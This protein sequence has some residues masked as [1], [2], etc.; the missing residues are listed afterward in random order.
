[1]GWLLPV[2]TPGGV[3]SGFDEA[4]SGS[5]IVRLGDRLLCLDF[6]HYR[7]WRAAAAAPQAEEL[8]TWGIAEGI[9]DAADRVRQLRDAGLLIEDG[10]ELQLLAGRLALRLLGECLGNGTEISPVFVVLGRN[11]TRLQVDAYVFEI[12][13]HSDGV[14]P[15]SVLCDKLDASRPRPGGRSCIE[16]LTA[17]LPVLV[18]NEV[19]LLEAAVR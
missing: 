11:K 14:S 12:L 1:M 10:P 6:P 5:A 9:G 8:I 19:I 3:N 15:V 18:R 16:A 7:L 13:L 4:P 2:G 17:S